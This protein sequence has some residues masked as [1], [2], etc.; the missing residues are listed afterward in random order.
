MKRYKISEV[1]ALLGLSPSAIR[2][3]EKKGMFQA[4]KDKTN[5]YRYYEENDII[6][7]R[8]ILYHR[9]IRMSLE[10]IH[11]LKHTDS[12]QEILEII[13]RQKEAALA[14][15][16]EEER[17]IRIYEFYKQTIETIRQ[18]LGILSERESL[19]LHLFDI[20]YVYNA[21]ST[22]FPFCYPGAVFGQKGNGFSSGALYAVVHD[23]DI[24]GL[25]K[26]DLGTRER[27]IP[28]FP[29]VYTVTATEGYGEELLILERIVGIA[30]EHG[31][32]IMPPYYVVY[33]A[34]SGEWEDMKRYY[35]VYLP[36]KE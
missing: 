7:I 33:L 20:K 34:T 36:I 6:K 24:D 1:G 28:P 2:F 30:K 32:K 16:K 29:C 19:P 26:I 27:V 5:G 3:Y 15:I 17:N 13:D 12:L 14:K 9:H 31:Y 22:I 4:K 8:S 21:H 35:E 25:D 18:E 10:S 23:H 11:N